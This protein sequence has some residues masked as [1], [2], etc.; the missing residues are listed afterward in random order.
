MDIAATSNVGINGAI[1]AYITLG[2]PPTDKEVERHQEQT[3]VESRKRWDEEFSVSD[4]SESDKAMDR[5][6]ELRQ[7]A[8]KI[9]NGK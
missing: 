7:E 1:Q 8:L 3:L 6:R 9:K 4:Y 2:G 5:L